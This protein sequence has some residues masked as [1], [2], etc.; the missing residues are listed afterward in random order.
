MCSEE[1]QV[2]DTTIGNIS[3]I[4]LIN[5]NDKIKGTYLPSGQKWK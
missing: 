2:R 3:C 5:Y 1:F 4:D